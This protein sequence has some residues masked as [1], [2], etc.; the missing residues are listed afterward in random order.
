MEALP[1][2]WGDLDTT[3]NDDDDNDN[4]NYIEGND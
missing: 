2:A 1:V 3:E 4:N